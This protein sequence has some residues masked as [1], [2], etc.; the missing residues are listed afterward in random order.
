MEEGGY[1]RWKRCTYC[2]ENG[3]SFVCTP[4]L[5][6][7]IW[8]VCELSFGLVNASENCAPASL[9]SMLPYVRSLDIFQSPS[10][11]KISQV[12]Q[13]TLRGSHLE[14]CLTLVDLG[15]CFLLLMKSRR[16]SIR[17]W[18]CYDF[19]I[20][21]SCLVKWVFEKVSLKSR[22]LTS[23]RFDIFTLFAFN[24]DLVVLWKI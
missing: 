21:I 9:S 5:H 15:L 14:K 10:H 19:E 23:R 3:G 18:P 22:W 1:E 12:G 7:L 24:I 16:E 20:L 11:T 13:S 2:V 6:L 8:L 4:E 17:M